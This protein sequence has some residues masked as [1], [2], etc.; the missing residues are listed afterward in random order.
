MSCIIPE[1][2]LLKSGVVH[3]TVMYGTSCECNLLETDTLQ[4][5]MVF[6]PYISSTGVVTIKTGSTKNRYI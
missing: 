6:D 5:I 4:E 2:D 1:V 3:I